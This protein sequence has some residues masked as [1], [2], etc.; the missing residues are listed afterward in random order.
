MSGYVTRQVGSI[1]RMSKDDELVLDFRKHFTPEE[2][3]SV[4]PHEFFWGE[5]VRVSWYEEH[6]CDC[7]YCDHDDE[8]MTA[9]FVSIDDFHKKHGQDLEFTVVGHCFWV[10]LVR[11]GREGVVLGTK[12]IDEAVE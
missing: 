1:L 9:S 2:I 8:L 10:R 3:A 4:Q 7:E 11:Q 5:G 6:E 12:I